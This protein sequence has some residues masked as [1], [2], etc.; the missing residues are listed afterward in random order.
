MEERAT[1]IE[2]V[3]SA[4]KAEA[5]P[6]R[7]ARKKSGRPD[8]NRGPHGPKPCA[9]SELRYAPQAQV[10][11]RYSDP[12]STLAAKKRGRGAGGWPTDASIQVL[13]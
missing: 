3:P 6:L 11:P 13:S 1:G 8:L 9:L 5:L 12:S 2:P 4:W 10:Y 7:Y